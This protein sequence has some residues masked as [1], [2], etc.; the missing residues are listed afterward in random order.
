MDYSKYASELENG[1][2]Q[3]ITNIDE[4]FM[5]VHLP[6]EYFL[7]N[8]SLDDKYI[9]T[10]IGMEDLVQFNYIV[11]KTETLDAKTICQFFLDNLKGN[12]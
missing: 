2:N 9:I 11:P 10:L 5:I 7:A 3:L 1:V 12:S 4:P 6:K 8:N